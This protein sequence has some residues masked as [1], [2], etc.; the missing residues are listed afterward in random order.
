[1]ERSPAPRRR[2]TPKRATKLA[3]KPTFKASTN[4]RTSRTD[5]ASLSVALTMPVKLGTQANIREVK[6]EL[7]KQL[8]SRLTTLQKACTEAQ[9]NANPA[10]CPPASFIGHARA[11]TPI[12]PVPLEGP[13]IFV[14]H[15]G[16]AFPSLILV[17]QGYGFT[18]DIVG[19]THI[20]PQGVTSTTF[21]TIPDEPVGSFQITIPQGQYSALTANA[22]LCHTT[23][24]ATVNRR[25]TI[26]VHSHR[27][28][29]TRR[30]KKTVAGLIMPTLFV[31]Q[32][33]ATIKQSTPIAVTGC[34]K[35]VRA[36]RTKAKP[37]KTRARANGRR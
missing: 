14:S 1:M 12:L 16:E 8:P 30:V 22:N 34:P 28:R 3:F 2:C 35:A 15:G 23:R 17:L 26:R 4:G 9:F 21:K 20:S 33:G 13:A 37:K 18:I 19:A 7:P 6:V 32:N 36:T 25:V 24:T 10:G 27:R 5:G 31:A 11:N 29:V